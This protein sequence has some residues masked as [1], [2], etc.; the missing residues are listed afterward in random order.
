[1]AM[2]TINGISL[3]PV[4]QG[5]ALANAGLMSAD[6]A[7]SN[8]ILIQTTQPLTKDQKDQLAQL[9]ARILEYVPESTY[10]AY[11]E[12]A[13][14]DA[15]RNLPFVSWANTYM[16]GFKI[17]PALRPTPANAP[18]SSLLSAG[19][20]DMAPGGAPRTVDVVLHRNAS[21]DTVRQQLAA[22]AGVD[23]AAIQSSGG[24]VRL[25]VTPDRLPAIAGI[26]AVRHVEDFPGYQL[27]NDV[28]TRL[29][30]VTV[31]R[32]PPGPGLEGQGEVIAVCDTGLDGG[33]TNPVHSAF[34]TRVRQLYALGR[35]GDASDPNGH[36]THVAGSVLGDD[37]P[38]GLGGPIRGSAPGAELVLQSVLDA[39]GGLGGIPSDLN[40]L[41]ATPYTANNARVH[42]NSWGTRFS[43]G[44]YLSNSFETD[45]FVANH[46]DCVICFAAGNDGSDSTATGTISPGSVSPPGTAKNCITVGATESTRPGLALTY[47]ALSP[48]RFPANPIAGDAVADQS[49]GMAAFS[50]RGPTRDGR[51]KP[52]VVAPG[53]TIL[54]TLSSLAQ[55]RVLFG[56]SPVQHYMFDAGTSMS[57]PL[58]AGC[59]A[60]IREFLRTQGHA[61]PSA[62]L[63]KAMLINGARAIHGQY[64]PPEVGPI[65][66]NDEGFGLVD[67]AAV[68]GPRA[69]NESVQF[70]DEGTQLDTGEQET[71]AIQVPA[72]TSRLKATLVWTDPPGEGLQ[73]D[74]DLI[75]RPA[76]VPER[77]GNMPAGTAGFDRVNNVE[78]VEWIGIPPG[79]VEVI[80]QA[81][82]VVITPQAYA[83]V[84][85][86]A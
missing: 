29:L 74:L 8:Y 50:G 78:Q 63:V 79:Q 85:R 45:E 53:C 21:V 70:F 34:G 52:D 73:N 23:P 20:P 24:K 61:A 37:N 30:R 10:I 69:A 81:F 36:G 77:H 25:T 6:S 31:V 27:A 38:A 32:Q 14:L 35:P 2:V 13:N 57:T 40:N 33:T 82:R 56:V 54:S 9:G 86:L 67:L 58:V 5:P 19:E 71:H 55:A 26:D 17:D 15:I 59:C 62:A 65:P 48:V 39:S 66:N 75:V 7:G 68:V 43:G 83:L 80:V 76:N 1:M 72:T 64:S 12:P 84:V 11:Y 41:F 16:Q 44:R 42:T 51:F 46:R 49:E 18:V 3:D 47:G 22:A 4:A 28:A 60:I